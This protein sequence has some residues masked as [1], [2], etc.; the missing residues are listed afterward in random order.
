M[1]QSSDR[2][3][4]KWGPG[5]FAGPPFFVR[6]ARRSI[7]SSLERSPSAATR[8]D[9]NFTFRKAS[10]LDAHAP[11]APDGDFLAQPDFEMFYISIDPHGRLGWESSTLRYIDATAHV[12]EVLTEL[13]SNACKAF[14]RKPGISYILAGK[15]ELDSALALSKLKEKFHIETLM[16]GGGA[17]C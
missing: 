16:L 4:S 15:T 5:K 6:R 12:V 7:A 8:T 14:L 9:D 1:S 3:N 2:K 17:A 10:A 13:A 11:A